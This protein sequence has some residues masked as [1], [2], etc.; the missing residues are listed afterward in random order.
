L[1]GNKK[2]SLN[3]KI[4]KATSIKNVITYVIGV[5]Y[6]ICVTVGIYPINTNKISF[7]ME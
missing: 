2:F 6:K 7:N 5:N 1:I 4:R 3:L